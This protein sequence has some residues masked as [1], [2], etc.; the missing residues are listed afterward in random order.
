[1]KTVCR[2]LC[3][4]AARR[5]HTAWRVYSSEVPG[6]FRVRTPTR[7]A[8]LLGEARARPAAQMR[9]ETTPN[10]TM[11][12]S[13]E[14]PGDSKHTRPTPPWASWLLYVAPSA[15][16]LHCTVGTPAQQFSTDTPQGKLGWRP[17]SCLRGVVCTNVPHGRSLLVTELHKPPKH[18]G[19][20]GRICGP[21]G[22][23]GDRPR[24]MGMPS[25]HLGIPTA[26]RGRR[27][28]SAWL[29]ASRG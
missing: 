3:D 25:W 13:A 19:F 1:M 9:V 8:G 12:G 20:R 6:K 24:F 17:S 26:C 28:S 2:F 21:R 27:S 11:V 7:G 5:R 18:P 10:F 23:F 14:C 15:R 22:A 16:W 4:K 29:C